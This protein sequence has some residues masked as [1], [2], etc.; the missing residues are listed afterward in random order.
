MT[1]ISELSFEFE[2]EKLYKVSSGFKWFHVIWSD[3]DT[4]IDWEYC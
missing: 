4:S 3:S 1:Q 2:Y